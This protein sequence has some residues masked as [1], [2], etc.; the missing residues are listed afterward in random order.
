MSALVSK[1]AIKS[2]GFLF[3]GVLLSLAVH[4]LVWQQLQTENVNTQTQMSPSY[5][6]VKVNVSISAISEISALSA[7][8]PRPPQK[9]EKPQ[10]KTELKPSVPKN[11]DKK[12]VAEKDV[13][14]KPVNKTSPQANKITPPKKENTEP[15]KVVKAAAPKSIVKPVTKKQTVKPTTI[16]TDA[17]Q[18]A[19]PVV[20]TAPVP[21]KTSTPLL[22]EA[23][24]KNK[25]IAE[26]M[27]RID[28]N[29]HYPKRALKRGIE[30]RVRFTLVLDRAGQLQKFE[31]LEG[32]RLFY[33]STLDA[34]KRSLP[35]KLSTEQSPLNHQL[36]LQYQIRR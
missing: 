22:S 1:R 17:K 36:A 5:A 33:K 31:W 28:Q 16:E 18:L 11:A 23:E 25:L 30:G 21:V 7:I 29:K 8:P 27:R 26:L 19:T 15:P 6:A 9:I 3:L 35:L 34:V 32:N 2:R 10:S 4:G 12:L 20:P 14:E 24:R 13:V